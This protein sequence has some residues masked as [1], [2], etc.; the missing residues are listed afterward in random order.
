MPKLTPMQDIESI[1]NCIDTNP[2]ITILGIAEKLGMTRDSVKWRVNVTLEA[3]GLLIVD[4]PANSK[5]IRR[6]LLPKGYAAYG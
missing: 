5:Y 4:Y 1:H 3:H 2:G 6:G